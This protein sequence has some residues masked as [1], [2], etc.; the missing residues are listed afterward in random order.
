MKNFKIGKD[1]LDFLDLISYEDTKCLKHLIKN[2]SM[3]SSSNSAIAS[4]LSDIKDLLNTPGLLTPKQLVV[5][6]EY[7]IN[8]RPQQ[9]IAEELDTSQQNI[10]LLIK[11]ALSRI[12]LYVE[13][14]KINWVKWSSEDQEFLMQNYNN[15]DIQELSKKLGKPSSRVISMYHY[16]KRKE[17]KLCLV[18]KT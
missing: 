18:Q 12:Q 6:T 8:D 10:S 15:T 2:L 17:E 3:F 11:S 7:L 13:K 4:V 1:R 5:I 16:L 14:G 9:E